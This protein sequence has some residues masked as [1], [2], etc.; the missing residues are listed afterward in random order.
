M[1]TAQSAVT[2]QLARLLPP[3]ADVGVSGGREAEEVRHRV[4]E[5]TCVLVAK[6]E[7]HVSRHATGHLLCTTIVPKRLC[8]D[9]FALIFS[10]GWLICCATNCGGLANNP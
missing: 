2:G 3:A 7:L 1:L 8:S 4:G 9:P 6:V 10:Q 5:G